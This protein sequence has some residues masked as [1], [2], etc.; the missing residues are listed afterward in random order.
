MQRSNQTNIIKRI[1][2]WTI[3]VPAVLIAFSEVSDLNYW[4][5]PFV[6][7]GTLVLI[8]KWNR[9]FDEEPQKYQ[10]VSRRRSF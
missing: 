3:G 4:Y 7:M 10:F 1:V 8:L 9:V 6:A 2:S 5:L